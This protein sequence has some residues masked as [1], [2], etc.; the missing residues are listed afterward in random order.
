MAAQDPFS[1]GT[2]TAVRRFPDPAAPAL[3]AV[4]APP[5]PASR[6]PDEL[7]GGALKVRG[8]L[9]AGLDGMF[10]RIGPHG[11]AQP[12]GGEPLMAG[13]R[14]REG[15]AAWFATRRVRTDLV[16]RRLGT[17][18]A[19]GPRHGLSDNANAG[20]I[21]HAGRILALGEG[22]ALPY[23]IGSDLSTRARHD[24]D[25]TLPGGFCAH[26]QRDPLTGELYGAAY[27]HEA[28]YVQHVIVDVAGR[29]R[30]AETI[31]VKNTPLMHA[32]SLTEHYAV[33]YD[34]PVTFNPAA[35]AAGLRVPYSWDESHGAR[36]G[37]LPREG[38]DADVVWIEIEPCFVF[39]AMNAYETPHGAIVLDVVR[40]ERAFDRDPLRPGE[41]RPALWRWTVDLPNGRVAEQL[42]H[43][44]LQ[45]YPSIDERWTGSRHRYGLTTEV[46]GPDIFGG[47]ALLLHDLETGSTQRHDFGPGCEAGDAVLAPRCAH[48]PEADGWVMSYVRDKA[49]GRASF[50]LLDT[51]DFT[52]EPVASVDL[53]TC[54][55]RGFHSAWLPG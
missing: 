1:A 46:Q 22:G 35:A 7:D 55:P 31:S 13:L 17:L 24:F 19:P 29:V 28:P 11:G 5:V 49:S 40:H 47:R 33:L 26:P 27:H 15:R 12:L 14:L 18:A 8:V 50:V 32:Y 44:G 6:C 38:N 48:A 37:F 25:G 45:E 4:C 41:G 51:R 39:H 23:E 20:L 2:A 21:R 10:V 36:L 9:P 30:R 53:P 52:G 54:G 16:S 43:P 42:L 34:L 3:R